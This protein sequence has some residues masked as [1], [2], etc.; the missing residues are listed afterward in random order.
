MSIEIRELD[1]HDEAQ[2]RTF[3]EIG[4]DAV[5]DRPYNTFLAWQAAKTY[6]PMDFPDRDRHFE[7]AWDGDRMVAAMGVSGRDF[8]Q[9]APG[10]GR[11]STCCRTTAAG[12][13]A[14]SCWPGPRSGP[15]PRAAGS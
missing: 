4:R 8:G 11:P 12:A 14:P 10:L 5:A 9:P 15:G 1:R 3:W 13:S 2:V 7:A 6:I